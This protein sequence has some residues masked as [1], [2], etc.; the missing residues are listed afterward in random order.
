MSRRVL[1]LLATLM[2]VAAVGCARD[3]DGYVAQPTMC[4]PVHPSAS[5][6][7]DYVSC[8][9]TQT[10]VFA[11]AAGAFDANHTTCVDA[12][13]ERTS[14]GDSCQY[15]NDCG[16]GQACT[17]FGCVEQCWAGESCADSSACIAF[18]PAMR[19]N[20]KAV[21]WCAPPS[22]DPA[23]NDCASGACSFYTTTATACAL[24]TGSCKR[25][26]ACTTDGDCERGLACDDAAQRCSTYCRVDGNDCAKGKTCITDG[27]PPL[28]LAGV[29]YG[30]CSL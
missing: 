4:D 29:R 19:V 7:R 17:D 16:A 22:C 15:A 13:E 26:D 10:C 20:G 23:G 11:N 5:A 18:A 8:L 9:D 30:Y 12:P 3:F 24:V 27:E 6:P 21:G 2:V 1:F 28:E 14:L 25:G